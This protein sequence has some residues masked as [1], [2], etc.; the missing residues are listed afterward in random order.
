VLQILEEKGISTMDHLLYSP[1]LAPDDF[2][3]FPELRSGLKG[4]GFLDFED[5]KSSMEKF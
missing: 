5:I 3:L 4:K 2:W 1:D